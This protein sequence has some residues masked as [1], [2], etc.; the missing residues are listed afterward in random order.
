[1]A[2]VEFETRD[3]RVMSSIRSDH[4]PRVS[5]FCFCLQP[6]QRVANRKSTQTACQDAF[7]VNMFFSANSSLTGGSLRPANSVTWACFLGPSALHPVSHLLMCLLVASV[8]VHVSLPAHRP[9]QHT[10]QPGPHLRRGLV[11]H[12]SSG[13]GYRNGSATGQQIQTCCNS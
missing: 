10:R 5:P 7:E 11:H 3:L 4:I 8:Q 13:Q 12:M 1:M 2:R 9:R 6:V